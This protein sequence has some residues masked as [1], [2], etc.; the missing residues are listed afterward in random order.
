MIK[1]L[2]HLRPA[3]L[4]LLALVSGCATAPIPRPYAP[5]TPAAILEELRADA[6]KLRTLRASARVEHD[7]PGLERVKISVELVAV[8][9]GKL[10]VDAESPMGGAIA[11]L[12]ADGEQF[13]MLDLRENRFLSGPAEACNVARLLQ[14]ALAPAEIVEV[15]LGGAPLE[16]EPGELRWDEKRGQEVLELARKDGSRLRLHLQP[17]GGRYD[18]V[19]AEQLHA[20]GGTLF[21]VA[22]EGFAAHAGGARLPQRSTISDVLRKKTLYL[23]YKE[24]EPNVDPPAKA[25]SLAVPNGIANEVVTCTP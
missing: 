11:T 13:R 1:M 18:L 10:R 8:R 9:G 19:A 12:V 20:D 3:A 22:H 4:G 16:G 2:D 23:R 21:K 24:V 5:R 14:V 25:F 15:L 6:A 7:G 17:Q